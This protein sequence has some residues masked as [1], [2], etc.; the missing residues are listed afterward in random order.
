MRKRLSREGSSF[1]NLDVLTG[2]VFSF[3]CDFWTL[4]GTHRL[5]VQ[6]SPIQTG[7]E[8]VHLWGRAQYC[9]LTEAD[10]LK[11]SPGEISGTL[12]IYIYRMIHFTD[13]QGG[14]N[15]DNAE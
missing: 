6:K 1:P 5:A 15:C 10:H 9:G 12:Y 4:L 7:P 13:R 14:G 2:W 8:T 11:A 3:C